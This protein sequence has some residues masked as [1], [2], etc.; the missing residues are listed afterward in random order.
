LSILHLEGKNNNMKNHPFELCL[1]K[2]LVPFASKTLHSLLFNIH[3][4]MLMVPI[5]DLCSVTSFPTHEKYLYG[6]PHEM[7]VNL[8]AYASLPREFAVAS[9]IN[10]YPSEYVV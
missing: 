6:I 1:L 8:A 4:M 2:Q 7:S 3:G 9:L 10:N 5:H